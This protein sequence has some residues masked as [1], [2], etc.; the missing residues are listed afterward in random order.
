MKPSRKPKAR[1]S[2]LAFPEGEDGGDV[3]LVLLCNPTDGLTIYPVPDEDRRRLAEFVDD[4]FEIHL[5]ITR[6]DGSMLVF[7]HAS[8][9]RRIPERVRGKAQPC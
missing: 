6:Q 1:P 2:T 4:L 7:E 9:P 5:T 3:K 8:Q